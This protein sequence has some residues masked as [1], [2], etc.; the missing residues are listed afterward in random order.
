MLGILKSSHSSS[1][2]SLVL[3]PFQT[4][5]ESSLPLCMKCSL[6]YVK[7]NKFRPLHLIQGQWILFNLYTL[8]LSSSLTHNYLLSLCCCLVSCQ[9]ESL[10][11]GNTISCLT[12]NI[13]GGLYINQLNT[14]PNQWN[15]TPDV[16]PLEDLHID[17]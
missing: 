15:I 2:E 3:K 7:I 4:L 9:N 8:T 16:H 6:T 1:I 13:D 12:I 14:T 5:K 17:N 10:I 11:V